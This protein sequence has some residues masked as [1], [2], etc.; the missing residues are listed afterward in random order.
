[1]SNVAHESSSTRQSS[2]STFSLWTWVV[3]GLLAVALIWLWFAGRGPSSSCCSTTAAM[4][5]T[6]AP[7]VPPLPSPAPTPVSA[8]PVSVTTDSGMVCK[9]GAGVGNM[10]AAVEFAS[11]S[12]RLTPAA[13]Q[14]LNQLKGCFA[15]K[16]D[17]VGHTDNVGE[18]APNKDLSLRRAKAVVAYL[19]SQG[20]EADNLAV[21]GLGE[22]KPIADNATVEGRAKN[23]RIEFLKR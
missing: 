19:V 4:V 10:S 11:G 8:E 14:L 13:A 2:R 3:A 7:P 22:E 6:P 15:G 17:V 16:F 21:V 20:A 5:S 18:A 12:A 1:M 23:R 9:E